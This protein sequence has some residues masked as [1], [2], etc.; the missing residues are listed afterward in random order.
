MI[1]TDT[2]DS[3]SPDSFIKIVSLTKVR[4]TIIQSLTYVNFLILKLYVNYIFYTYISTHIFPRNNHL[5]PPYSKSRFSNLVKIKIRS[6]Y[7]DFTN[8]LVTPFLYEKF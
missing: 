6:L 4:V 1:C 7:L 2:L 3:T 5:Y 8:C